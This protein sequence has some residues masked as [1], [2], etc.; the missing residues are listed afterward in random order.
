MCFRKNY[1]IRFK[2]FC[3]VGNMSYPQW[4]RAKKIV[5]IMKKIEKEDK[6][7]RKHRN[8]IKK[9]IENEYD[10]CHG[11]LLL[12]VYGFYKNGYISRTPRQKNQNIDYTGFNGK[13]SLDI[14]HAFD[15]LELLKKDSS[16]TATDLKR[17][18]GGEQSIYSFV[19]YY[20][21]KDLLNLN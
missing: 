17:E 5:Q 6:E 19:R 14:V 2:W 8:F 18:L 12:A 15:A 4:K 1:K 20:F 21:N 3:G 9:K 10:Y 7:I 11:C 16:L 13:K